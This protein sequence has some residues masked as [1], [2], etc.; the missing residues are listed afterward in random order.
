MLKKYFATTGK[1]V[2]SVFCLL[3]ILIIVGMGIF[4]ATG[5]FART[6]SIGAENAELFAFA[7]AGVDP[8]SAQ[9]VRS[10]FRYRH[11]GFVY[12]VCFTDDGINYTYAISAA[13]GTVISKESSGVPA[14]AAVTESQ[15]V[16][17]TVLPVREN[18]SLPD[19]S[20]ALSS[21]TEAPAQQPAQAVG[22]SALNE[23]FPDVPAAEDSR[24]I[25]AEK[26]RSI[27]LN[28]ADVSASSA[29]FTEQKLDKDNGVTVYDLEF[30]TSEYEYDYEINAKTG[31]ITEKSRKS[32]VTGTPDKVPA[33]MKIS[34]DKAKSI[35]LQHA[36]RSASDV[37]FSK[38]K[39]DMEDGL[40]VYE[41]EFRKGQT[42]YEYEIDAYSGKILK[43]DRDND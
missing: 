8:A 43:Y 4:F 23:L 33:S 6:A 5:S 3:A 35:A 15:T 27:A 20:V 21:G 12:E 32:L 16:S 13:D 24:Y 22:K 2:R 38:A 26:A 28:D 9:N 10:A 36:G 25:G 34:V 31:E 30:R 17:E 40:Y 42:E 18:D 7:D 29:E 14:V 41:I 37:T 1:T 11:G 39:L 19:D